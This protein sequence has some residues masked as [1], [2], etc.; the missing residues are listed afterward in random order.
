[1]QVWELLWRFHE[2]LGLKKPWSLRELEEELINPWS[3]CANLSENLQ[4]SV[5]RSQVVNLDK[6]DGMSG[7]LSSSFQ[8]SC[9]V[10]NEDTSDILIQVGNE[11]T[12]DSAQ[13]RIASVTH[14]QCSGVALTEVY[15]SLLSVLISEL[16]SKV[17]AFADPNFD[18]GESKSKRGRR[19]RDG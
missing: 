13:D 16:Q 5:S 14:S 4:R 17:A 8:E 18:S 10:I 3:D 9:K 19:S 15:S 11:G 7:S 6:V 12:N 2:I 1:M